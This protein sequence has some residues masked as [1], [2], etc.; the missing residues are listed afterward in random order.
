MSDEAALSP[1]MSAGPKHEI[2]D[3]PPL[4]QSSADTTAMLQSQSAAH[5]MRAVV[6]PPSTQLQHFAKLGAMPVSSKFGEHGPVDP[7]ELELDP[8]TP[9]DPKPP[10]DPLDPKPPPDPLDPK[11]PLDPLAPLELLIPIEPLLLLDPAPDEETVAPLEEP[12]ADW[13]SPDEP[14]S[15]KP[16]SR[17][18]SL[19]LQA[20]THATRK[21]RSPMPRRPVRISSSFLLR[22]DPA[23]VAS[24]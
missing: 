1:V 21:A 11:P 14:P 10:P 24:A 13:P 18:I 12:E 3:P 8:T 17:P 7:E 19:R 6:H 9:L 22:E 15:S 16:S 20:A 2:A 5:S 23:P 4:T